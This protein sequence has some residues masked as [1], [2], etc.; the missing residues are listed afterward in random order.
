MMLAPSKGRSQLHTVSGS[1]LIDVEQLP[2][3][4]A[5]RVRWQNLPPGS[6][7]N[8]KA[9]ECAVLFNIS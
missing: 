5:Q 2:S 8:I 7:Q 6:A 1:Q 3:K 9:R 4:V